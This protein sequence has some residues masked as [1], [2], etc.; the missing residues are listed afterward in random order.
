LLLH[1]WVIDWKLGK[2]AFTPPVRASC[3]C[4]PRLEQVQ[5]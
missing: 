4:G 1:E 2:V 5:A 3:R